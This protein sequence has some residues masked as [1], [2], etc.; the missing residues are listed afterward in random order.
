[1]LKREKWPNYENVMIVSNKNTF[2]LKIWYNLYVPLLKLQYMRWRP[3][4][5][6]YRK[7]SA[8]L[9]GGGKVVRKLIWWISMHSF[10][11]GKQLYSHMSICTQFGIHLSSILYPLVLR[12]SV[13]H[14]PLR[15]TKKKTFFIAISKPKDK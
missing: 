7:N 2:D 4:G 9:K 10:L 13:W 5:I 11:F 14:M 6:M 15:K 12:A 8:K 3:L 1:M